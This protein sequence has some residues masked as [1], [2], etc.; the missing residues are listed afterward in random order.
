MPDVVFEIGNVCNCEF[1][2]DLSWKTPLG[3]QLTRRTYKAAGHHRR[4]ASSS[5]SSIARACWEIE[6]FR[7]EFLVLMIFLF[8]KN[9]RHFS[10]AQQAGA[11]TEA[12]CCASWKVGKL[13][14]HFLRHLGLSAIIVPV[15][16]H[17]AWYVLERHRSLR[18]DPD[19]CGESTFN[20]QTCESF[21]PKLSIIPLSADAP[22]IAT[23][24]VPMIRVDPSMIYG[25]L[26][27]TP[28]RC[29]LLVT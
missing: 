11:F 9:G 17:L 14:T 29:Q 12:P 10:V 8:R 28:H 6:G 4:L 15:S 13:L 23:C 24:D 18:A 16:G 22:E 25:F 19:T 3:C 27:V 1:V 26:V 20:S 5:S 2:G 7:E 21:I